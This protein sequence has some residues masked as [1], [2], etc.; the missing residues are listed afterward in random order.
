MSK[1]TNKDLIFNSAD[2]LN[3]N[4]NLEGNNLLSVIPDPTI[5][6][7]ETKIV[8]PTL[9]NSETKVSTSNVVDFFTRG[10]NSAGLLHVLQDEQGHF[11]ETTMGLALQG[12]IS[13]SREIDLGGLDGAFYE[14]PGLSF[15]TLL[16]QGNYDIK[17]L[18]KTYGNMKIETNVPDSDKPAYG[19]SYVSFWGHN[20]QGVQKLNNFQ[21]VKFIKALPIVLC[22]YSRLINL[23]ADPDNLRSIV[24]IEFIK[25]GV[26]GAIKLYKFM[27]VL[28]SRIVIKPLKKGEGN[29]LSK[30]L[31][32]KFLP[33]EILNEELLDEILAN[34]DDT[35]LMDELVNNLNIALEQE[36]FALNDQFSRNPDIINS[37][38]IYNFNEIYGGSNFIYAGTG[39][40]RSKSKL[41]IT[42]KALIERAN[43]LKTAFEQISAHPEEFRYDKES[44]VFKDL[45]IENFP[46]VYLVPQHQE[47]FLTKIQQEFRQ[48]GKIYFGQ[49]IKLIATTEKNIGKL[50]EWLAN[51]NLL[52]KVGIV[53]IEQLYYLE[54]NQDNVDIVSAVPKPVQFLENGQYIIPQPNEIIEYNQLISMYSS[55]YMD[56]T[57]N[58]VDIGQFVGLEAKEIG[59]HDEFDSLDSLQ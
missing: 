27:E 32:A 26:D 23:G 28:G 44:Q 22:K 10:E 58:Q 12:N 19:I 21:T 48:N 24:D 53:T 40:Y 15:S 52:D 51:K 31:D 5:D 35:T 29:K 43:E 56:N 42:S 9:D 20:F 45:V 2:Q 49:D 41:E 33:S 17:H 50:V 14:T 7:T 13:L 6:V 38:F 59:S 54:E 1:S 16:D 57:N 18:V 55:T 3:S 4:L 30:L 11:L 37:S 8:S 36:V 25:E 39:N 46:I 34:K 47:S